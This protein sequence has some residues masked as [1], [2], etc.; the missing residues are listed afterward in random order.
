MENYLFSADLEAQ[1]ETFVDYYNQ[2]RATGGRDPPP[3]GEGTIHPRNPFGTDQDFFDLDVNGDAF[4]AIFI[5]LIGF[6]L[7]AMNN[8]R[9]GLLI[10]PIKAGGVINEYFTAR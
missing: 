8:W 6:S 3:S 1:I 7:S 2:I 10:S 5:V 9:T 4:L